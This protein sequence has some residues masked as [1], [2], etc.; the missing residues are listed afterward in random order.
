MRHSARE[1]FAGQAIVGLLANSDL[2]DLFKNGWAPS[3]AAEI[4]FMV[5][6]AMLAESRK[7]PRS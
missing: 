5:A 1:Y 6:D 3:K 4:C 7:G 2:S